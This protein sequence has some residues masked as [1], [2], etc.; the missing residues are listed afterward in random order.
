MTYLNST[1]ARIILASF[2]LCSLIFVSFPAID[3]SVSK[4]FFHNGFYSQQQ[5]WEQL[6]HRGVGYF[7][8]GS[9]LTVLA[10]YVF[11]KFTR[12]KVGAVDGKKVGY[13]LLVVI[14]GAGVL[15]NA[16]FKDNFGRARPRDTEIFGGSKQFTP[17]FM[18]A[19]QCDTNCSFVSGDTAAAFFSLAL[20]MAFRRRRAMVAAS[21][22]FG[23]AVSFARLA[24]GAHFLS[25]VVTAS[26]VML[27]VSDVLYH[28]MLWPGRA[29][30][31]QPVTKAAEI[32]VVP[33]ID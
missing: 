28:Y 9:I 32:P 25:D 29:R 1:R 22:V 4:L 27:I 5:W 17:A 15:V 14:L 8:G 13:L 23:A 2:L 21:L 6:L 3:I 12:K 30:A 19:N 33:A 31:L 11:N 20:V 24:S 16:V 10:I 18:I 26:F 7:L